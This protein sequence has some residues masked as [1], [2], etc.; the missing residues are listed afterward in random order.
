MY[1]ELIKELNP[2][3]TFNLKWY[4][5]EDLY[6]EGE[7]E[8]IIINLIAQN[9]P[10]NYVDV[11]ADNYSWSTYYHLTHIRKNILNWYPF[12]EQGDVLEIGCGMGAITSVLCDKCKSVTAV[13]LSQK[14]AIGTLVRCREKDNLEIIVGNLNDIEFEKKFDY[15]TLIGVLEYQGSYTDTDNPYLD[16]L[17]KIKGLLKPDGKLLV[18]IENQY[19]LKYW[20][21]AREDHTAIPFEGMNQYSISDKK[22]RTF[23]KKALERLMKESGFEN[24]YFYYPMPD[25][26]MPMVVYSQDCLPKNSNMFNMEYYY[27]PDNK[28]LVAQEEKIYGDLIDNQVFDFFANSFLVECTEQGKVGEVTFASLSCKRFSEY[29]IGTRF[30]SRGTVEKFA[31]SDG[32]KHLQEILE[33][34]EALIKRGIKVCK[35]QY[36]GHAIETEY[37]CEKTLE[38][39]MLEAYKEKDEEKIIKWWN[40]LYEEVLKSSPEIGWQDNLMYTFDM[41]ITPD[42]EKYGPI[43]E[44]GYLDLIPR[45][46]FY[47]GGEIVWFDQEWKLENVPAKFVLYRAMVEFYCAFEEA[48]K[49][50]SLGHLAVKMGVATLWKEFQELNSVFMGVVIDPVLL[51]E[52]RGFVKDTRN[53]VINNLNKLI[54]R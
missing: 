5:D 35:S 29:N 37:V 47:K 4:K 13:E 9:E 17:K 48:N 7:I 3:P 15:I 24:V 30:T 45:N 20:C 26:K 53:A 46:A 33:N 28:T 51:A 50:L 16:F 10:E 19:G 12:D 36:N 42:S 39:V 34:E 41:G 11:I 44:T 8:D 22:V 1:E 25:Y 23:S 40:L 49:G 32:E 38:D 2:K 54:N 43:L 21:G 6:S 14:R 27:V 31:L 18:A 52:S